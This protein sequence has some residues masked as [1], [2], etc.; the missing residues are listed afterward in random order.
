M[1]S[2]IIPDNEEKRMGF[3]KECYANYQP[4]DVPDWKPYTVK[5]GTQDSCMERIGEF[6]RDVI[7]R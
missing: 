7:K 1:I 3:R 2:A 5:K 6:L 4:L